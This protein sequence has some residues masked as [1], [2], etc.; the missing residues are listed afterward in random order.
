MQRAHQGQKLSPCAPQHLRQTSHSLGSYYF[1][2]QL[3]SASKLGA[4]KAVMAASIQSS[5]C[6]GNAEM[7]A[8]S[9]LFLK[10][11]GV[12]HGCNL[13]ITVSWMT[14]LPVHH[15]RPQS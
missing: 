1:Y 12:H 15:P 11:V 6:Q 10:Y 4:K 2:R 9:H 8:P 7:L 3:K 13:C 5:C 14:P